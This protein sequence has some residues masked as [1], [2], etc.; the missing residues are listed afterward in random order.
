MNEHKSHHMVIGIITGI[1]IA[2]GYQVG[3][4]LT[5]ELMLSVSAALAAGWITRRIGYA[6]APSSRSS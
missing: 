6:V 5:E 3:K 2:V 1:M 4:A